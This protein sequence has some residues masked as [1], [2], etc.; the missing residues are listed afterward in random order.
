MVK[1]QIVN[2]EY[3]HFQHKFLYSFILLHLH[4]ILSLCCLNIL[5][6]F[7]N[8]CLQKKYPL[9]ILTIFFSERKQRSEICNPLFKGQSRLKYFR[10]YKAV[11]LSYVF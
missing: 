3:Q 11:N 1:L 4:I 9:Y 10:S 5:M 6:F 8:I 2:S 7:T